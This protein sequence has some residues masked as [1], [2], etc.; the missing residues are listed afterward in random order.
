[1]MGLL[2]LW[3]DA[4]VSAIVPEPPDSSSS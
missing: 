1:V 4:G 2:M 3:I